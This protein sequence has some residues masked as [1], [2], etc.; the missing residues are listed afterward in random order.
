MLLILDVLSAAPHALSIIV[1]LLVF[2]RKLEKQSPFFVS[3]LIF[4]V[5]AFVTFFTM[6]QILVRA[7]TYQSALFVYICIYT[8]L[9]LGVIYELGN[10]LLMSG[11]SLS[12]LLRRVLRWSLAALVLAAAIGSAFLHEIEI[13]HWKFVEPL[14]VSSAFIR[15]GMLFTLFAFAW[16]LRIPWQKW[17]AGIA[18]G[19]GITACVDLASAPLRAAFGSTAIR[20]VD[21][22]QLSGYNVAVLLWLICLLLPDRKLRLAVNILPRSDM[23]VWSGELQSMVQRWRSFQ[24]LINSHR[25]IAERFRPH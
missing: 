1:L 8:A 15:A 6:A 10:A 23:E 7:S 11:S 14:D 17:T 20:P 12:A 22:I 18:L 4:N 9:T 3:Y 19:F 13:P 24:R 25:K 21:I 2:R 16:T 5:I